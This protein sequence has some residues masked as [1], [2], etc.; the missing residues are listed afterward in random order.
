MLSIAQKLDQL[1]ELNSKMKLLEKEKRSKRDEIIPESLSIALNNLDEDYSQKEQEIKKEIESLE[2]TIKDEVLI[3]GETVKT[4]NMIAT[5]QPGRISWDMNGLM[6]YAKSDKKI[7]E[8]QRK[9]EPYVTI[10][11]RRNE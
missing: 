3:L 4:T 8:F 7:L 11:S 9:S 6:E 2:E 1:S 10:K 5:W